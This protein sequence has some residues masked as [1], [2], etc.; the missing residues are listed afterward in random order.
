MLDIFKVPNINGELDIDYS[1]LLEAHV[2]SL[3]DGYVILREG[4]TQRDSWEIKTEDDLLGYIGAGHLSID[5]SIIH[6]DGTDTVTITATVR[7]G[8]NEVTFYNDNGDIISTVAVN[9]VTLTATL[10]ITASTP[11]LIRVR[12]G[13]STMLQYNKVEVTAQ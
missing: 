11:R 7:E 12:V 13:N 3:V 9:P 5:K 10:Q 2:Y 8:L 6:A 4:F 1:Y